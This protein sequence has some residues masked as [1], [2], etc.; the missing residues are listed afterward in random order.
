MAQRRTFLLAQMYLVHS[1][2][3]TAARAVPRASLW[4]QQ[5]NKVLVQQFLEEGLV[6]VHDYPS[7]VNAHLTTLTPSGIEEGR[8]A[9]ATLYLTGKQDPNSD[10][11]NIMPEW[12]QGREAGPG[13]LP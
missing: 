5:E 3:E 6:T 9:L 2:N 11:R 12:M 1:R 8:A 13:E 4:G 7:K 10:A